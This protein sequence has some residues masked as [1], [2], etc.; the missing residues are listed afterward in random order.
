MPDFIHLHNHTQFS[1]L[2]GASDIGLLLDKAKNDGQKAVAITDHGNMFGA[3]KFVTEA[4][5]RGIKPIIGC[6]FYV[7][8]DRHIQKFERSKGEKDKRYHQLLIAKN[9]TGYQNLTQLASLGYIEG[10]YGKYPRIDKELI[11]KYHEGLIATSC[12][13]AGEIP[14]AILEGDMEKAEKR[15]RWWID[16][17]GEDYYIEIQRHEGMEDIDKASMSQED[18]NQILLTLAGKFNLKTIATNDSHYVNQEDWAAHDVL[19]SVNT[20]AK[21]NDIDRF[22]FPSKDYYFMKK[23]EMQNLFHDLHNVLDN[24]IEIHDKVD[25]LD[26]ARDVVLPKFPIPKGFANQS[27]YLKYLTYEGAKRRYGDLSDLVKQ[28]LEFELHAIDTSGYPGYFLIVQDF[29]NA[30]RKEGVVVGPGRGSAAGSAVAYCLGITAIDPIKYNLLFERFLNPERVSLPDIDIDFDDDGR[31][32]VIDYVKKKY[33]EDHV[34]QI[35]TYGTM[36]ARMA[37]RDVGRVMDIP[38]NIVDGVAKTFPSHLS[39]TLNAILEE[40]DINPKLKEELSSE[41][42]ENAYKLRK[43]AAG[44]DAIAELL[45]TAYKLEGS[46]RNTGVHACGVVITPE[47]VSK[48]VPISTAK[49]IDTVVTQFDNSVVESAGLLK[50]D[51]LGLKTLSIIKDAVE[52][53]KLNKKKNIDIDN[54]DLED[55]K[56][57]QL[58]QRGETIGIF[59]YESQGMQKHLIDLSPNIFEDLIA[60][61]AL[62]RPGPMKYIPDFVARKHGKQPITYDLPEMEEI[63]Q[64]TYGITVYQE[65]VMLLSQKLGNLTKGQADTLRKGMGKK[66]MSLLIK[67]KASFFEGCKT[68]GYPENIVDKI[69]K[70]WEDFAS[71]AFNKSHSTCYAFIAFQTAYLKANFPAQFMAAVLNHNKKDLTKLNFFLRESKRM[72]IDVLGPDINESGIDFS[73]NKKGQIRFGLS[74]LKGVGEGPVSEILDERNKNGNFKDIYDLVKRLDTSTVTKKSYE[75]LILGGALDSSGDKNRAAFF[76]PSGKSETFIEDLIKYGQTIKKH[77]SGI[78]QTLFGDISNVMVEKP[79]IPIVEPWTLM[80]MLEK[81]KEVTGIYITGHPLE[82]FEFEMQNFTTNELSLMHII[83]DRPVKVAGIVTDEYHSE[84]K[85]GL[86]YGKFS[87]QDFDGT[88]EFNISNESYHKYNSMLKKG[89]VVFVEGINQKG[90]NSDNYFFKVKDVKLL[91]TVGKLLTKS[92]TLHLPAGKITQQMVTELISLCKKNKGTHRLK[93]AFSDESGNNMITTISQ[94]IQVNVTNDFVQKIKKLGI[95]YKIN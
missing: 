87:I 42:R 95:Q 21:L 88:L 29:I 70:D 92:I 5:K 47:A 48:Y 32:K 63:L 6:E 81:E 65:Q 69:W 50:M 78:Q 62:Y 17:F 89:Q 2:D 43:M 72:D 9:Q 12:C 22:R 86:P 28:R 46:V 31:S 11:E 23:D 40:N 54:V 10:Q 15:L 74:A 18:L 3:F 4:K 30:G 16:I 51:F 94:S 67:V 35:I 79:P 57:F 52:L 39:A 37:I 73:V 71:Y 1:L 26:L 77:A 44:D 91:D 75:T 20:G 33:G 58:F 82:E 53:I 41:D 60:M 64:E 56:T 14:Q 38:L 80:E 84:N 36:K 76:A 93:I 27:E 61:N 85:R 49:G 66:D 45:K 68:N 8:E 13:V 59:Q 90:Y 19:L 25:T 83:K 55:E 7:V 34:A 24:T